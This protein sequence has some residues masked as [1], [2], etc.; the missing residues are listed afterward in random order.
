MESIPIE[1]LD[2]GGVKG[3]L[4][5]FSSLFFEG[6]PLKSNQHFI[7]LKFCQVITKIGQ[8]ESF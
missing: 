8:E 6:P 4:V 2:A 7:E 5:E 1:S 3:N